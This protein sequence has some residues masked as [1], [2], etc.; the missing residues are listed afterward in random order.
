MDNNI[1][2]TDAE[3]N[4]LHNAALL[5]AEMT[6]DPKRYSEKELQTLLLKLNE[7]LDH[8]QTVFE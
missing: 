8:P 2:L 3:I 6:E 5:A 7:A 4:V 1:A